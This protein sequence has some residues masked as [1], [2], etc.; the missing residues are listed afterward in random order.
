MSMNIYY[1]VR[2]YYTLDFAKSRY[3]FDY[4]SQYRNLC[5]QSTSNEQLMQ[6][7]T[8]KMNE[9]DSIITNQIA[10]S[11]AVAN[12]PYICTSLA[13]QSVSGT[14]D[15]AANKLLQDFL[16]DIYTNADGLY[17]IFFVTC[18]TTGVADGLHGAALHDVMGE[19]W[20]DSCVADGQFLGNN[21]PLNS[22]KQ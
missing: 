16:G 7:S 1:E 14:L 9:V 8:E 13:E 5:L 22:S 15:P 18:N 6:L 20:Y 4:I 11:K 3:N 17:E 10:L 19:P 21:Q 12:S 2:N